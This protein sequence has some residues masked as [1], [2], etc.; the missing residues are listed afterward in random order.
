MGVYDVVRRSLIEALTGYRESDLR[1]LCIRA[2][3]MSN[4][5]MRGKY[6]DVVTATTV[7]ANVRVIDRLTT[8]LGYPRRKP[9]VRKVE[10]VQWGGEGEVAKPFDPP[11]PEARPISLLAKITG[12]SIGAQLDIKRECISS[13]CTSEELQR[14]KQVLDLVPSDRVERVQSSPPIQAS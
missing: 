8:L 1:D 3:I 2:Q 6:K 12:P 5:A 14:E 10:I 11:A 4:L 7:V 9:S 13:D